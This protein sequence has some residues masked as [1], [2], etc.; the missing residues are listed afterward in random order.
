MINF[1]RKLKKEHFLCDKNIIITGASRGIGRALAVELSNFGAN[2]AGM[3]RDEKALVELSHE[4][5]AVGDFRLEVADVTS[6]EQLQIAVANIFE[7]FSDID[8]LI[9]SAGV[10]TPKTS[11]LDV[12]YKAWSENIDINLKGAFCAVKSCLPYMLK[13]H[14]EKIIF[15]GSDIAV[16][17]TVNCSAYSSSKSV[18]RAL[19]KSLAKE[20]ENLRI[21]VNE[22]VPGPVKTDMN[23]GASGP[24]WKEAKEVFPIIKFL[25][26]K[27]NVWPTGQVFSLK[28]N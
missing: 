7:I 22:I 4:L 17:P 6:F 15:L 21:S 11:I 9:V 12:D 27:N 24:R 3:A 25:L 16:N 20:V 5:A 13:K 26:E 18:L 19:S 14:S 23:P 10:I 28:Q 8:Y 2:V 1:R